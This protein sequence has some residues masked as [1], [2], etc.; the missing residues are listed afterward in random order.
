MRRA[1][2]MTIGWEEECRWPNET[3]REEEYRLH[4]HGR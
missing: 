2:K 1:S 4:M 3:D